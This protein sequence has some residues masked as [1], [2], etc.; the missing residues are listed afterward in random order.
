MKMKKVEVKSLSR[1]WHFATPWT[2]AYHSPPSM[3]F[4]RQEY[5]SG[6][7]FH[8]PGHLPN[9]RTEPRSPAL[10]T[11]ALPSG[12]IGK[13]WWEGFPSVVSL[14]EESRWGGVVQ[15]GNPLPEATVSL[16]AGSGQLTWWQLP[17]AVGGLIAEVKT[18]RNVP[19]TSTGCF[20][21]TKSLGSLTLKA[22]ELV[23]CGT[24]AFCCLLPWWL[25]ISLGGH[26]IEC[27]GQL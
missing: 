19:V 26:Y 21:M 9:P 15:T 10:Q 20:S 12:A 8:P 17:R 24:I 27:W 25:L 18:S 22:L 7:P 16:C 3:G 6:L 14:P 5:Q 2:V 1:V 13:P 11:D 4:S 23:I